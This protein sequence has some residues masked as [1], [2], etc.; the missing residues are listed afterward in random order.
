MNKRQKHFI[1][2]DNFCYELSVQEDE[3]LIVYKSKKSKNRIF[4]NDDDYGNGSQL[5]Y[6][7][8]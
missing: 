1:I 5:G 4:P 7:T 8:I 3:S 2:T 6:K